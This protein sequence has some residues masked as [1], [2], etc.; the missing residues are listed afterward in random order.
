[1][2]LTPATCPE[3][4]SDAANVLEQALVDVDLDR[5]ADGS[6]DYG[7][8][9]SSPDDSEP[10]TDETGKVTVRCAGVHHDWQATLEPDDEPP[11]A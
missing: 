10:V 2:K 8:F 9:T 3:C 6:Y 7:G 5:L 1:M 4:G 11:P